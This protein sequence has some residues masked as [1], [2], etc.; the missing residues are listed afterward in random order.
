MIVAM[1]ENDWPRVASIYEQGVIQGLSTF[2]TQIPSYQSWDASHRKDCRLVA[3]ENNIV[4][5]WVAVS[6]T[7]LTLAYQGV[8]EVSLYIDKEW[9]GKGL[10]LQLMQA[11]IDETEKAG[12]WCLY[13][14]ICSV[15]ERSIALHTKCG[16]RI[17]GVR[18][19]IAKDRFGNW[20]DTTIMERRSRKIL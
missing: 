14:S 7:S 1:Q 5:G 18:E 11:L 17:V 13:S 16:F 3:K 6:P 4:V 9:Q 12:Y 10:G 8:V 20:Q 2:T 19:K 15:N